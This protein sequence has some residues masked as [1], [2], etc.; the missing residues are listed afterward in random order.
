MR[1]PLTPILATL[2]VR[3]ALPAAGR[4]G[5]GVRLVRPSFVSAR[6]GR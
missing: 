1:K 6:V 2:A 4:L 3:A 5:V